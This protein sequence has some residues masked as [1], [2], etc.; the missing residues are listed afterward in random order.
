[1]PGQ[2]N[3]SK[4]EIIWKTGSAGETPTQPVSPGND[5]AASPSGSH[6]PLRQTL[7][8]GIGAVFVKRSVDTIRN[9]ITAT[10]GNEAIQTD[11]NNALKILGYIGTI[12]SSP[13][14][15]VGAGID[16]GLNAITYTREFSR[17]NRAVALEAKLKGKRVDISKSSAYYD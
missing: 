8:F 5:S 17:K 2:F 15:A 11:I 16:V 13:I 6:T 1:M 9:E 3:E 12:A 7:A 14:G 4:Y 10:T